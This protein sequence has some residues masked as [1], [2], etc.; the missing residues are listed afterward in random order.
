MKRELMI[1]IQ[2]KHLVNILNGNKTLELR[3]S[4]PKD[5]KGWVYIY[6]TKG[7]KDIKG[8]VYIYRTK[9]G[10]LLVDNTSWI[11]YLIKSDFVKKDYTES[12]RFHT[13]KKLEEHIYGSVRNTK[14][15][16]RFWFDEYETYNHDNHGV[17]LYTDVA[18]YNVMYDDLEKLCLDYR[19]IEDYGKGKDLYAWHIKKLEIFDTPLSLSDFYKANL[20]ASGQ[21]IKE[22]EKQSNDFSYRLQR[23]PQSWQ[24]V[25]SENIEQIKENEKNGKVQSWR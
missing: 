24:Y 20:Y 12:P 7:I 13:L 23:P 4:V 5:Y 3:K 8:R 14:V 17:G 6:C 11:N 2:P 19:E 1:S 9:S 21:V 25:Y 15:V 18:E 22:Y 16:A 10:G